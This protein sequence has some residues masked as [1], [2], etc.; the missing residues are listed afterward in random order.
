MN[1]LLFSLILVTM[2]CRNEQFFFKFTKE[3][4]SKYLLL[5]CKVRVPSYNDAEVAILENFTFNFEKMH[6]FR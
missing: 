6:R 3:Q 4:G 2:F 1:N 5:Q